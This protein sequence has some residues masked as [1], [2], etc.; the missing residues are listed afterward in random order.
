MPPLR[1]LSAISTTLALLV[2]PVGLSTASQAE[3]EATDAILPLFVSWGGAPAAALL[4]AERYGPDGPSTAHYRQA[5]R[6]IARDEHFRAG[7][8][9][10]TFIATVVLQLAAA[11]RLSLSDP[12]ERYLPGVVRGAHADGRHI[13]LRSLLTHTSGLADFTTVTEGTVPLSPLQA[14]D[15]AL[16]LPPARPGRYSYS[17]T[18]YVLLGMVIRQV[19]G[20]SYA[21][22]AERRLIAPLG[23]TGTSFPGSHRSLPLP[24]GRAYTADGSDVTELDPRVAGAAG[25]LVSW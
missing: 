6:G 20:H 25:E 5:G 17:S 19:T 16:D 15:I 12:V 7:S 4:A 14:V 22:E 1:A 10:K 23:L 8:V 13:S 9:T 18:N 3:A 21:T 2:G 11:H 24:H